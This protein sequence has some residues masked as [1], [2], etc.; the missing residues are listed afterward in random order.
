M[1]DRIPPNASDA[2]MALLGAL[3][4][5][6]SMFAAIEGLVASEDF[7]QPMHQMIFDSI[8]SLRA[9]R[10][11]LDKI[12]LAGELKARGVYDNVGKV[13]YLSTLMDSVQTAS[14][15]VYY[16]KMI[17]EKAQLR[18]LIHAGTQVTELGY[19]G[20]DDVLNALLRAER[21]VT[22][23]SRDTLDTP[24]ETA[25][26]AAGRALMAMGESTGLHPVT[27]PWKAL[28]AFT[29][30]HSAGDLVLIAA[31][32]K[33]GK[34]AMVLSLADYIAGTQ[35]RVVF[36][37]LEMGVDR[38]AGRML[39][40]YSGVSVSR[41]KS[42]FV[43][44]FDSKHLVRAQTKFESRQLLFVS[45]R[46]NSIAR[47]RRKLT[48]IAKA[49]PI[50]AVVIDH[51]G[52]LQDVRKTGGRESKNSLM[53][54]AYY[55]LI[56]IANDFKTVVF[57][58]QHVNR[59]GSKGRPTISD[60]RDGGNP[61]GHAHA[62][63]FPY[64]ENPTGT[65]EEQRIGEFI[66]G[67]CRDGQMGTAEMFFIGHRHLWVERDGDHKAWFEREMVGAA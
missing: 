43:D 65:I 46:E 55:A 13:A 3:L 15:A 41:Q 2:E 60:L 56:E 14:S 54:A 49:G 47:I 44:E 32:P 34:S 18:R 53:D 23:V 35:G 45:E 6:S 21:L 63:I 10:E 50:K 24:V 1:I 42:G 52:W 48:S 19:C 36:F 37:P 39:A 7:Y 27:T 31:A 5:D 61:E 66:I 17:R 9:K 62:I 20:E 29:G 30:G 26:E 4:V 22:A 67:A 57:A 38:T 59:E 64:R 8:L 16:A 33:M 28:D 40:M 58:V 51:V 11:P 12:S 25:Y